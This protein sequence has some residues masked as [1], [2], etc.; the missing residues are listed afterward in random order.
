MLRRPG[1]DQIMSPASISTHRATQV[2]LA[3]LALGVWGLFLR[4]YLPST[5]AAAQSTAAA[6]SATFDTL[7]V[8]RIDVVDPDGKL[9]LVIANSAQLPGAIRDGKSY[10]RSIN[11]AAGV[12]FYDTRGNETGGLAMAKQYGNDTTNLSFDCTYQ[13]TDCIRIFKAES[14]DGT[15]LRESVDIYDRRPYTGRVESSQ[16][17]ERISLVDENQNAALQ[18]SDP[19]GRPRIR[20]GV[21][22]AGEPS[23]LMLGPT[24][25]EVY[26]AGK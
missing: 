14:S 21:D 25:K 9:R 2:L 20:I 8:H 4:P 10:Q 12:L 15:K 16:G 23:I 3:I 11:D 19:Q 5:T 26:R 13:G 6:P 22:K 7:T 1:R 24:G 17:I 18:L